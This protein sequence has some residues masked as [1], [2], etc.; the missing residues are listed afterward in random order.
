MVADEVSGR[1]R[2][3]RMNTG[4]EI[5]SISHWLH[6]HPFAST[7]NA[8]RSGPRDGPHEAIPAQMA[9][10]YGIF[11]PGNM[12]WKLAPAVA[13]HGEPKN[14]SKNRRTSRPAKLS[15]R[16][17]GMVRM[18]N[19]ANVMMYGVVRP[20]AGISLSGLNII[21]PI[22]YANTYR[23]RPSEDAVWP[24]W[25]SSITPASLGV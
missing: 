19:M 1:A 15:T 21:G 25:N 16:D 22:P 3:I 8:E 13:R 11:E 7:A 5:Q 18:T 14:P 4:P 20:I 6:L 24:T 12:S 10:I 17:V 2:S 9:M 23:A